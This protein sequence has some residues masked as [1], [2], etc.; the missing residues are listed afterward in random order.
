LFVKL[1]FY[2]VLSI[3]QK[4]TTCP[5]PPSRKSAPQQVAVWQQQRPPRFFRSLRFSDN[6]AG[7]V[8]FA[9][10]PAQL[11]QQPLGHVIRRVVVQ[12]Y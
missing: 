7:S 9:S 4:H 1:L 11:A 3:S 2:L 5:P 6:L 8:V 12:V 10:G